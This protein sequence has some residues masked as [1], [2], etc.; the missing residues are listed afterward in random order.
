[1]L[2]YLITF[3][4]LSLLISGTPDRARITSSPIGTA[5]DS[6]QLS[7]EVRSYSPIIEYKVA[8]GLGKV[9]EY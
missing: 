5:P 4:T 2:W 9:S 6:Y 8:Y 3:K 7:W 1:M